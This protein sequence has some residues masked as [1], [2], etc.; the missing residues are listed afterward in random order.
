MYSLGALLYHLLTRQPPFQADTLTTLLKQVVEAEPVPPCSLNP[1]IPKDLETICLK[2]LEKEPARRYPTAQALADDLGRFL[3]GEPVRARPVG[4]VG[5]T[6]RWCRRQPV[7]AGLIAGLAVAVMLGIAGISWE[8]RRAEGERRTAL[9]NASL[10]RRQGYAA[11]MNLVQRSLQDGDLGGARRLLNKYRPAAARP[12]L[13]TLSSQPTSAAGNGATFGGCRGAMIKVCSRSTRRLTGTW[14]WPPRATCSPCAVGTADTELWD[15]ATRQHTG[16][17]TNRGSG[18]ALAFSPDGRLLASGNRDAKGKPVISIWDVRQRQIIRNLPQ[19]SEVIAL[20]FSPD[21]KRLA[22]FNQDPRL[23]LWDVESGEMTLDLPASEAINA[24][25]RIP[26]FSPDGSIL[27]SGEMDGRIRLI[28]LATHDIREIPA[29]AGGHN[30]GALAFSPDG[31]LLATGHGSS[32]GTIRLWDVATGKLAGTLEGHRG[33]VNKLVFAPDGRTLYSASEDQSIRLWDLTR[34][35]PSVRLQG[36]TG[37]LTGLVLCRDGRT[38]V[39]CADD[40]SVRFWDTR[41][42]SRQRPKR[43]CPNRPRMFGALF[44]AD[45][46][47]VIT[48]S[49]SN[50]VTIWDV[51]TATAIERIPALGTNNMSVA[52]SPDQRLL[53]VGGADGT[54]QIWDLKAQAMVKQW[55]P[56]TIPV[57]KLCFLEG[58]KSLFSVAMIAHQRVEAKRW[59]AVSWR[60]LP[61]RGWGTEPLYGVGL[62]PDQRFLAFPVGESLKIWNCAG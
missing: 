14:P 47:R 11:D 53:A 29:P 44:T 46:R 41:L 13:S 60:E 10:L 17:L 52:L 61:F 5:K 18:L 51:A 40:G 43:S 19:P 38:L 57:Y 37:A 4:A 12:Q 20:A 42:E 16:T 56:H 28:N 62:S 30:T 32:D 6:W 36:H 45:S 1:S 26:L 39:S 34:T 7:R 54:L 9:A 48:A 33:G 24:V 50:A 21:A 31:R 2:C 58:G 15:L 59:D 55:Q 23:R 49:L 35:K 8:W 25:G 3:R 22:T 27:A